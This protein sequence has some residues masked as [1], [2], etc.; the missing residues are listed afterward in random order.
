MTPHALIAPARLA[1]IP[2]LRSQ[3]DERLVDL[4][5]AG[6]VAA[7]EAIVA[8]YRRPLLRY[9][10]RFLSDERAEDV[11]QQTFISAYDSLRGSEREMQLRA[12]LYRI[13]HNTALNALRD[14][15][16]AHEQLSERIDGVERP[17]QAF[18]KTQRLREVVASVGELPERQ[19]DALVLREL[20][21]RSYEEIADSLGVSDGAV[22]Q[23]LHRARTTVRAGATAI[24]PLGLLPR[25]AGSGEGMAARVAELCG[26]AAGGALLTKVCATALV[27]GAVLG[28][29]ATAPDGGYETG[30]KRTPRAGQ[31]VA[32]SSGAGQGGEAATGPADERRMARGGAEA[33]SRRRGRSDRSGRRGGDDHASRSGPGGGSEHSDLESSSGPGGNSGPG[34]GDSSGPGSSGSGSSGSGS[35]SSGS[36]T[37]GSGSG[38]GGSGSLDSGTSGS[39][40]GS[41]GT[42][43]MRALTGSDTGGSG[44]SDSGSGS[45]GSGSSGG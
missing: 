15:G 32:G 7:F 3:S 22:R 44:S 29:V 24:T 34:S 17:D 26:S 9:C 36:G 8:R 18:E 31:A 4:V 43:S 37:S 13:A 30:A 16:R 12:W 5:R 28:G 39:G 25:V 33:R 45:S 42:G 21:G 19:R 40:S 27:T 10:A 2:L 35:S 14:A 23:L 6:N 38:S 41:S 11:V 20:E 1:G